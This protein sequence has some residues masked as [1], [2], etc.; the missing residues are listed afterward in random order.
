VP[1]NLQQT[2]ITL[3]RLSGVESQLL[4]SSLQTRRD[5][6]TDNAPIA[7]DLSPFSHPPMSRAGESVYKHKFAPDSLLEGAGSNPRSPSGEEL[8]YEISRQDR[9]SRPG[10]TAAWRDLVRP[11]HHWCESGEDLRRLVRH[12]LIHEIGHHFG[13]SDGD[14]ERIEESD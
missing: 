14:M 10:P 3:V 12:V 1:K 13:F 2:A 11:V 6:R 7:C 4:L 9:E 8:K 5:L